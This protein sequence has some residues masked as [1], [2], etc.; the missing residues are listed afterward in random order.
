M[1]GMTALR[2]A[3]EYPLRVRRLVVSGAPAIGSMPAVSM[4]VYFPQTE[5]ELRDF[6]HALTPLEWNLPGFIAR[7][8]LRYRHPGEW[9][10]RRVL[11]S[12]WRNRAALGSG[13][14]QIKI[15][16]LLLWGDR[17]LVAPLAGAEYL[18]KA[19]PQSNLVILTGCG[20]VAV[21]DC[22]GEAT[23]AMRRFLV[24]D[25]PPVGEIQRIAHEA[26]L[27]DY[28]GQSDKK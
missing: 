13:V 10:M 4:D 28:L 21:H 24:A 20:H 26:R 19:I 5:A 25:V 11:D 6:N 22:S 8:Y 23:P 15:P 18:H 27:S 12:A 14:D 3:A 7:D 17:D 9:V 16:V 2:F 1:G